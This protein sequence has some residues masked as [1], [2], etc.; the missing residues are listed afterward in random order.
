MV[1]HKVEIG[2]DQNWNNLLERDKLKLVTKNKTT[3]SQV[4]VSSKTFWY[5]N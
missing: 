5:K 4:P 3:Y 2:V 1:T